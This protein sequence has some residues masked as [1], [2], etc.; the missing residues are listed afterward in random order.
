MRVLYLSYDGLTDPLGQSQILPYLVLLSEKG[1]QIDVVSFEK[2]ERKT[3]YGKM[4]KELCSKAGLGYYPQLYTKK[5]PVIST[6]MDIR[7]MKKIARQLHQ[8]NNYQIVH[9]RSYIAGIAGEWMKKKFSIPFIFD[10]RGFYADERV[11]GGIWPQNNLVYR[12]I[13]RYFKQKERDFLV[14]AD[15][16]ISLTHAAKTEIEQWNVSNSDISVIPCCVDNAHFERNNIS[17]QDQNA[18]RQ[19]LNIK[20]NQP[21]VGYVGSTGTWY[22]LEEMLVYFK[23]V[24]KRYPKA[25]FL[26]VTL[27]DPETIKKIA[28]QI[29]IPKTALRIEGS[30]RNELPVYLSLMDWSVFFIKPVFSKK[31]SSPTKQ[32]EL[33]SMGVPIVCNSGVGDTDQIVERFNAGVVLSNFSQQEIDRAVAAS[34]RLLSPD[35][36]SIVSGAQTYFSLRQGVEK[37]NS[38][39]RNLA[40]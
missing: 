25:V 37:L 17:T 30:G 38:I 24:L 31:A 2:P 14:L 11:D 8:K 10:M 7:R 1:H 32:G 33:M 26:F 19:K 27:D 15:H 20:G 23:A 21:V 3:L 9:C 5:P 6:L 4:I 28:T 40:Q 12:W 22:L 29:G 35:S 16:T 39:Y 13:Y 36:A 18:L 34:E